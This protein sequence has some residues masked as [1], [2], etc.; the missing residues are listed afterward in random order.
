MDKMGRSV[1]RAAIIF[2]L[3]TPLFMVVVILSGFISY[4]LQDREL[5]GLK[6]VGNKLY[7]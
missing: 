3:S 4:G 1:A 5:L 6:E 2:V 7:T